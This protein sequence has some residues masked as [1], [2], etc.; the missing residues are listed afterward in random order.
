MSLSKTYKKTKLPRTLK[1]CSQ[2]KEIKQSTS[3]DDIRIKRKV[4]NT[5]SR[6]I[7]LI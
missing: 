5:K 4:K 7:L 6:I 2:I 1:R 3:I